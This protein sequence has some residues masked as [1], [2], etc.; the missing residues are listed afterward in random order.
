MGMI[1][2][3]VGWYTIVWIDCMVVNAMECRNCYWLGG[4]IWSGDG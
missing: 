4:M 1:G 2:D 3:D